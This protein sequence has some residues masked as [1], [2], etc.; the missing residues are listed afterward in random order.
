MPPN[1]EA[2]AQQYRTVSAVFHLKSKEAKR[3]LKFNRNNETLPFCSDPKYLGTTLDRTLTYRRHLE[4]LRKQLTSHV[5]L[6]KQLAG[7]SWGAGATTLRT[8]TLAQVHS[9]TECCA[10]ACCRS[11]HTFL[12]GLAINDALLIVTGWLRPASGQ[13]FYSRRYST[14]W[15]SSQRSHTVSSTPCH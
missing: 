9:T 14:C 4:S 15:A 5:S 8:A 6:L 12:S 2:K 3:E 1:L 7:S 11:A 13:P 10:P